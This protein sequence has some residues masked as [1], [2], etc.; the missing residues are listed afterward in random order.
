MI[1]AT[2]KGYGDM[3]DFNEETVTG[4]LPQVKEL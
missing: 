1:L 2:E 4:L 3:F